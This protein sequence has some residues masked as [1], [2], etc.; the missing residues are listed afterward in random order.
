MILRL[1][2]KSRHAPIYRQRILE[3][4]CLNRS[5]SIKVDI[6]VHAVSLGEVI[7][8]TP[9]IDLFLKKQYSI[10]ITTMT[11]TG[12]ARV[13]DY[14]KDKVIHQ[15]IP[16]DL[17]WIT[18]K[19]LKNYRPR[20]GLIMETEL[21]PNLISSAKKLNIPLF[22]IN[23]RLSQKSY[24]KYRFIKW[25]I[26]PVINQ[27]TH[28]LVQTTED[29]ERFLKLGADEK[30]IQ[31]LGNIKFDLNLEKL[32]INVLMDLKIK[33]GRS[34]TVVMLASTHDDEESQILQ[35][36][37]TLQQAIP[38]L[39]LLIA[40]RHQERFEKIWQLSQKMGYKTGRRTQNE[41]ISSATEVVILDSFGELISAYN[42]SDYTFVGGSLVSIGGHNVLEPIAVGIP[43][44][45]GKFT[46]NFKEIC[47]ILVQHQALQLVDSGE[48]LIDAIISLHKNPEHKALQVQ[49]AKDIVMKNRGVIVHYEKL[50]GL[51]LK[52]T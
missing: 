29:K 17:P 50:V 3:R 51:Y 7:A 1:Y 15:Y 40:P 39:L 14:F 47:D 35:N 28:I 27:F 30:K 48:L 21:W 52:M 41:T 38:D 8:V 26:K 37:S 23:G 5:L 19:F 45:S 6:W 9:L 42:C 22:L 36:I 16:Y 20:V 4:F 18:T 44:F 46:H 11:P 33:W 10:L 2:W 25:F 13:N 24:A 43:V 31:V 49:R 32:S 12:S 34:R